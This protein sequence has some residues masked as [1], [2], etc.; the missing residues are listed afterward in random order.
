MVQE[1]FSLFLERIEESRGIDARRLRKL[2]TGEVFS[3]RQAVQAGLADR[4]GGIEDAV[5]AAA[6]MAGVA[7]RW[8]WAAPRRGLRGMLLGRAAR[9]AA[10]EAVDQALQLGLREPRY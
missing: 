6:A 9:S 10:L 5:E 7:P 1:Y 4:T 2:A 3:G 8:G